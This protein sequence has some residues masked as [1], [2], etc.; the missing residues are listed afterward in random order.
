MNF[1]NYLHTYFDSTFTNF[2][3]HA[4]DLIH[5][6]KIPILQRVVEH[7]EPSIQP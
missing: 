3:T 2:E 5:P 7:F 6:H 4:Y 1:I